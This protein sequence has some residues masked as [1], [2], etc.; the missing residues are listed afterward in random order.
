VS[1]SNPVG[2]FIVTF[3]AGS[4]IFGVPALLYWG[5]ERRGY[6]DSLG[7]E[8]YHIDPNFKSKIK[9]LVRKFKEAIKSYKYKQTLVKQKDVKDIA[10][11]IIDK[12]NEARNM[13][14]D[15]LVYDV[16]EVA[17]KLKGLSVHET[18][19]FVRNY[20]KNAHLTFE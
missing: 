5:A 2:T 8:E 6:T 15:E 19:E 16:D 1:A 4:L 3:L 17:E 13:P 7:F 10:Q 9:A 12:L 14:D 11:I 20:I 18:V